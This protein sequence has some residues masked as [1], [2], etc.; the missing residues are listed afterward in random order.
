MPALQETFYSK[1]PDKALTA[2][3]IPQKQTAIPASIGDTN[4]TLI[5]VMTTGADM[6]CEECLVRNMKQAMPTVRL[7]EMH[8]G[9]RMEFP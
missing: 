6:T 5:R 1:P 4:S 7:K 8:G 3:V 2:A 9:N